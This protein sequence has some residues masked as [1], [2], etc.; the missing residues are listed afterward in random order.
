MKILAFIGLMLASGAGSRAAV[1]AFQ[2]VTTAATA[3]N[4]TG[5]G[6]SMMPVV[7]PNGRFVVFLSHANNLVTNDDLRPYLDVFVRD[8]EHS[9]TTLLSIN[10]SGLGGGDGDSNHAAISS[11]GQF[12]VFASYAGNLV[13]NDSNQSSDVFLRDLQSG[14]IFLVSATLSGAASGL[15]SQTGSYPVMTPDAR[16]IAFASAAQ[17]LVAQDTNGIPDVFARDMQAGTTRLVSVGAQSSEMFGGRGNSHS[18]S[19][20]LEGHRIAFVSSAANVI[21]GRTNRNGDICVR[22]LQASNTFWASSNLVAYFN[23]GPEGFHCF[24][25]VISSDGRYVAFKAGVS[26][27]SAVHVFY[28][29]LET[30]T[31]EV[32]ST[33][34]HHNTLPALS[35]DGQWLAFEDNDSIYLR[36]LQDGTNLL[37]SV[38]TSGSGA[39]NRKSLRPVITPSG[40]HVAFVSSASDLTPEAPLGGTNLFRIYVRDVL[41]GVTHLVSVATNGLASSFDME[42]VLPSISA[43]GQQVVFDTDASDIVDVDRNGAHDVFVRNVGLARTEL[44]SSR[45]TERLARSGFQSAGIRDGSISADGRRIA[46]SSFDDPRVPSDTNTSIDVFV[47]DLSTGEFFEPGTS[48][49]PPP[50]NALDP[51]LSK[52]GEALIYLRER[53]PEYIYQIYNDLVW[54]Q[55]GSG[56]TICLV[57]NVTFSQFFAMATATYGAISSNGQVAV[58]GPRYL[59]WTNVNMATGGLVAVSH[60]GFPVYESWDPIISPNDR[61][62]GFVSSGNF[63]VTN[64][65][66]GWN[67]YVRD[68][69]SNQTHVA[70]IDTNGQTISRANAGRGIFSRDSRY[71]VFPG[72]Y[73]TNQSRLIYRYDIAARQ[74][75]LVCTNCNN[76]SV[77]GDGQVIAYNTG[78]PR[79]TN[80]YVADLISGRTD[81]VSMNFSGG[82][83]LGGVVGAPQLSADGRFV[84]FDSNASDLVRN[85]TNRV[86]DVFVHDRIQRTTV[87]I[88]RSRFGPRSAAGISSKPVISADG[89]TVA[90]QS[91]ANDLIEGDYNER[92]DIFVLR[93]GVGDSDNDGMDDDWEVAHFDNLERDGAG[94]LDGDGQTDRQ[95]FVSGTDPTNE[96]SVLRVLTVSP[97]GGGSTTVMWAAVPDRNYVVQFKD[98]LSAPNWSNAS[99]VLTATSNSESFPHASSAGQR[100]YRVIAVQ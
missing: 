89:R 91:F 100:Y 58:F 54:Q 17:D 42:S 60:S 45:H 75:R 30:G 76:P 56:Q 10:T 73:T 32:I 14:A 51:V 63:I 84:V 86:S 36:H 29:D 20:T 93:L 94:D 95:E 40:T 66:D 99:G 72:T 43:D 22:D 47:R 2:L 50:G 27:S 38:N 35:S 96:G 28:H 13:P 6:H 11:N 81:L 19:I 67:L 7:S 68:I 83:S 64:R 1:E 16:W 44:I 59:S 3:S 34:S 15:F 37:V 65:T 88:S 49:L 69:L 71:V 9:T 39:A 31:T 46:F 4:V 53:R 87:L 90:F 82:A 23:N 92:R 80:I 77:S 26:A 85:D 12:V 70:S 57:T 21:P 48:A 97:M 41:A 8:L 98:S 61:W 25:P 62:V 78:F 55:V 5:A 74:S 79:S 18:P 24:N 52:N 33:N